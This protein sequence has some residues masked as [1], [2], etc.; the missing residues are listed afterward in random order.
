MKNSFQI[1]KANGEWR[2]KNG[3]FRICYSAKKLYPE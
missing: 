2:I 3:E 1:H